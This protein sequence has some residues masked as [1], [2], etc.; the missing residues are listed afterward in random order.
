MS[1]LPRPHGPD[2]AASGTATDRPRPDRRAVR[3]SGPV[4]DLY[5]RP[6]ERVIDFATGRHGSGGSRWRWARSFV[7]HP[8]M[9]VS[10][11]TAVPSA[12]SSTASR[13]RSRGIC[14]TTARPLHLK[15]PSTRKYTSVSPSPPV[16]PR[17]PH[18]V[19]VPAA[20]QC[21]MYNTDNAGSVCA[22]RGQGRLSGARPGQAD[23][24]N[25]ERFPKR[26]GR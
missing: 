4:P 8:P 25:G 1:P 14:R 9:S 7:P 24:N 10:A 3:S 11:E 23:D 5:C 6:S 2:S 15:R 20:H 16:D 17:F 13:H 12:Q 22:S 26:F 21:G 19:S 18:G